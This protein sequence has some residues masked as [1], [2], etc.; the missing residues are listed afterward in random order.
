MH[1]APMNGLPPPPAVPEKKRGCWFYG[2]VTLAIVGVVCVVVGIFVARWAIGLSSRLI[3]EFTD[4]VPM[5][6]ETVT[7]SPEEKSALDDR[8]AAFQLAMDNQK[9]VRELILTAR[10]L[11]GLIADNK[12][13]RGKLFVMIE[14]DRIKGKLSVP[15]TKD[16]GP[17]KV[18]GRYLNG[19]AAFR[20]TLAAGSLEVALDEMEGKGKPLPAT[21]MKEIAKKNLAEDVELDPKNA[22]KIERFESIQIKDDKVIL[23]NKVRQTP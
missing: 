15:L 20:V 21:A 17:F 10:E 22:R 19:T 3:N 6:I 4:T 14:G 1:N 11:N 8:L 18:K 2:C 23:R 7:L 5:Q 9:E 12:D 16:L 13:L